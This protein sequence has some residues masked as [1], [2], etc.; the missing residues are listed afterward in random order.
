MGA[1][2]N[3]ATQTEGSDEALMNA[4]NHNGVKPVM[5]QDIEDVEWPNHWLVHAPI[6]EVSNLPGF[7]SVFKGIF[8]NSKGP[9]MFFIWCI[10]PR[11]KPELAGL[12]SSEVPWKVQI[13]AIGPHCDNLIDTVLA[14]GINVRGVHVRKEEVIN[15]TVIKAILLGKNLGNMWI[16]DG[17]VLAYTELLPPSFIFKKHLSK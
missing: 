2:G 16:K 17:N 12:I 1:I 6:D 4:L 3:N 8:W 15:L 5:M 9:L 11:S 10:K 7:G 13:P 14:E